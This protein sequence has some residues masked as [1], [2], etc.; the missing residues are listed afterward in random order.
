MVL[1]EQK[2]FLFLERNFFALISLFVMQFLTTLLLLFLLPD[3]SASSVTSVAKEVEV[4]QRET[5]QFGNNPS[6]TEPIFIYREYGFMY[7]LLPEYPGS[8]QCTHMFFLLCI[9]LLT[10]A[11]IT[12]GFHAFSL[13]VHFVL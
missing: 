7:Q 6:A 9:D 1:A 4:A 2:G 12:A 8:W 13:H 3:F 11:Y 5:V 10:V